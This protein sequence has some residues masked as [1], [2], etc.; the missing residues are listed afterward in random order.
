VWAVVRDAEAGVIASPWREPPAVFD[1]LTAPPSRADA[2]K[3]D[4]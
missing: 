2:E 3:V 4:I 1:G